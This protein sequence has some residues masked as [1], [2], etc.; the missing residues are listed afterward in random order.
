[1]IVPLRQT[2]R[3]LRKTT[4][5]ARVP[6]ANGKSF[7]IFLQRVI[8]YKESHVKTE[9]SHIGSVNCAP[10]WKRWLALLSVMLLVL[11]PQAHSLLQHGLSS[12]LPRVTS[13]GDASVVF[14]QNLQLSDDDSPCTLCSV[15]GSATQLA[16]YQSVRPAGSALKLALP[17]AYP[18]VAQTWSL[19]QL[20][21]PP[22]SLPLDESVAG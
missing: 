16:S 13:S 2:G 11:V 5:H 20:S 10:P 8:V 4:C 9:R 6:D 17:A 7:S 12:H 1:M 21:R 22:P 19:E 18:G 14:G 3:Q 15:L